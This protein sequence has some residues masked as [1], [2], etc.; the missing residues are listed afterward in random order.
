M[1]Q[2]AGESVIYGLSGVIAR[3][4]S[5][6]LTPVYTRLFAPE[7]YGVMGLVTATIALLQTFASLA[8]DNAAS[9]WYWDATDE[10][11]RRRPF[12]TW[13]ATQFAVATVLALTMIALAEPLSRW[14]VG[15]VGLARWF[16]IV[17]LTLPTSVASSVAM[18]WL[19]V[20]R[21]PWPAVGYSV[22]TTVV[23]IA[24]TL[25]LVAGL[26][27]G[28]LG[29]YVAQVVTGVV[30][31]VAA[32][33]LC[34]PAMTPR[35]FDR[36]LLRD[37]LRFSAPLIPAA[38]AVWAVSSI[39]RFF[40]QRYVSTSEVGI[41]SIGMAIAS[42]VTLIV[43]A[44][45]QAWAP[46]ALSIHREPDAHQTYSAVFLLYCGG[47][48]VGVAALS[49]L[50]PYGILV[51]ATPA[52]ARASLV[53]GAMAM[54]YVLLGLASIA[55]IG[56]AIARVTGPNAL[57]VGV[58][59]ICVIGL[60]ALLVPRYG[61]IGS[62]IASVIGQAAQPAFLLWRARTI[63][64][65]PFPVTRGMLALSSAMVLVVIGE[66]VLPRD[67]WTAFAVR[68]AAILL[69]APILLALRVVTPAQLK[70]L[71][72]RLAPATTR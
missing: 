54:S 25:F 20:N 32:L 43:S 8:L 6:W 68:V 61:M 51:L 10:R 1:R 50:A 15:D 33:V 67:G 17:A 19:R 69:M 13:T 38:V 14:I 12:A 34:G 44:F 57:A 66:V 7:E 4:L 53:V 45:Q 71:R 49:L 41:Y 30:G 5:V 28:L 24:V 42:L 22:G 26:R 35:L 62:A 58:S 55:M 36:Q 60:N 63:Y 70:A 9:R 59:S 64:P 46:F 21:R 56:F 23:Q 29:V 72:A 2:L 37:M 18:T 11:D 31:V 48:A 47:C 39:D 27:W 40:V 16:R 52:Y 65:I 3:F